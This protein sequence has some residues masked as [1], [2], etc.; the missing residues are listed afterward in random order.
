[1]SSKETYVNGTLA[2]EGAATLK[3]IQAQREI[4]SNTN[5]TTDIGIASNQ[6]NKDVYEAIY[7]KEGN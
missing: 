5:G 6:A 7:D 2:N 4:F 3:N 1:M